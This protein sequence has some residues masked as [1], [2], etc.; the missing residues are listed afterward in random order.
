VRNLHPLPERKPLPAWGL[1]VVIHATILVI[2]GLLWQPPIRG[3]GGDRD[4]PIGIALVKSLPDRVEYSSPSESLASE[5]EMPSGTSAAGSSNSTTGVA[6]LAGTSDAPPVDLQ[7]LLNDFTATPQ[8]ATTAPAGDASSAETAGIPGQSGSSVSGLGDSGSKIT[9]ELFG[10]KGYGHR[11]VYVMDRSDSMNGYGGRPLAAAKRELL[12]SVQSMGPEQE[13]QIIFYNE[14]STP[15]KVPGQMTQFLVG[16]K[17][18]HSRVT[19]VVNIVYGSGGT[20]HMDALKLALRMRPDVVFILTD[21]RV[22]RMSGLQLNEIRARAS[23]NNTVIHTIEFGTDPVIP[24]DSF[25][26]QLAKG[27]HGEY[28]YFNVNTL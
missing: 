15:L 20:N 27:N 17:Q 13:F 10:V 2:L 25:L 22:P 7:A 9:A 21:A 18:T 24:T 11:F 3:T 1:S 23:A 8:P 28:R 14:R 6:P 16:D 12:R 4:R 26:E 19:Q 5:A